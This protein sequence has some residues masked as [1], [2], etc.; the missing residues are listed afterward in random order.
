MEVDKKNEREVAEEGE[1][2]VVD[3]EVVE[4]VDGAVDEEADEEV[5]EEVD[6]GVDEEADEE[7]ANI[8]DTGGLVRP[9]KWRMRSLTPKCRT[10]ALCRQHERPL[11][12]LFAFSFR[13][14]QN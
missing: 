1:D 5:D 12:M 4:K 3:D 13:Y 11:A 6:E 10:R 2:E 7:V 14:F 8:Q 9:S